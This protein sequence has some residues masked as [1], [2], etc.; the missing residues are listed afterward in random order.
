MMRHLFLILILVCT[1]CSLDWP[2]PAQGTYECATD[3][4]CADGYYCKTDVGA[5]EAESESC[6]DGTHDSYRRYPIR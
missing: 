1:G 5:C 6:A 4:D 3:A 2:D